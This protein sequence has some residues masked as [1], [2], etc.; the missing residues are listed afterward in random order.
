[1]TSEKLVEDN[2]RTPILTQPLTNSI[3]LLRSLL[4]SFSRTYSLNLQISM[5]TFP[6]QFILVSTFV[7]SLLVRIDA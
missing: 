7:S 5:T 1:M 2:Y 3:H 6:I 4:S